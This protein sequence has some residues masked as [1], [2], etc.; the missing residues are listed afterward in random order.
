MSDLISRSKLIEDLRKDRE[1]VCSHVFCHTDCQQEEELALDLEQFIENAPTV[2]SPAWIPCSERLPENE[3]E[4]EIS[5][6][7]KYIGAGDKKKVAY[8][9]ARAFYTDGTMT[10]E[11]SSYVW[12]DCDNWKYDEEK[13]AYIIPE[14]WW[15]YVTFSEE[16]GVVDAEVIAW[17]P[18]QKPYKGE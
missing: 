4:V 2:E 6:I 8:F 17:Q 15:E 14:G 3:T 11:D 18:L 9:T 10:T 12:E 7:R 13:D 1:A 5:C 16:F